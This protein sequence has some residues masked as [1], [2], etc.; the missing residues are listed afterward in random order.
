MRQPTARA[1]LYRWW[2]KALKAKGRFATLR[3]AKDAGVDT[4]TIPETAQCGFYARKGERGGPWLPARIYPQQK[5]HAKTGE[6][7]EDERLVCDWKGASVQADTL[8]FA[9][10]QWLWF[11]GRPITQAEFKYG[12]G[13]QRWKSEQ[14]FEPDVPEQ[15]PTKTDWLR[16][17]PP[18]FKRRKAT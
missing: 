17:S 15:A 6:L 13:H 11:A 4:P 14:P 8:E 1:P 10:S 3:E 18:R 16:S 2:R 12:V 7:L 9:E 5:V